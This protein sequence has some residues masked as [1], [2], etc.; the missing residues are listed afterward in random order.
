MTSAAPNRPTYSAVIPVYNSEQI[1]GQTV[2]RT[3]AFFEAQGWA[4]EIILVNDGSPDNSWAIMRQIAL[5]N[6]NV[7]SINLLRNYGQHTAL[8]CG[9][10]HSRGDFVITLDDDLQNPPEEI[11]NLVKKIQEGYDLV[12]GRF[13][14]KEHESYRRLGSRLIGYINEKIFDK[15]DDLILTNFR[16]IRRDV[17]ERICAYQTNAPYI[18]G[19]ALMF[20]TN[21]GN[22]WVEHQKRPVGRSN[23]SFLKIL[24]LVMRI[25]FNYSAYPLRIVSTAG[26]IVAALSFVLGIYY[27]I[28][29]IF[30]GI[31]VPGW[32]TLVVLVA[33]FNG[34]SLLI[35]AMLGEYLIRLLNQVTSSKSYYVKE[36]F[37][38]HE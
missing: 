16:I 22:V 5:E 36:S 12:F 27:L 15:P 26:I 8:Y 21:P 10:Q 28:R 29:A 20:A 32:A 13:R 25:L 14:Q 38:Q 34:L 37:R 18:P 1:I 2:A 7:L 11:V 33:F 4:Y 24:E 3:A 23:Y 19:L 30:I 35:L 9:L 31:A 17:V 6:P